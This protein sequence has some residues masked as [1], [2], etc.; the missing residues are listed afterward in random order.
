M[1][2]RGGIANF[3]FNSGFGRLLTEELIPYIDANY[4]TLT[5]QPNRAMAGLSMGGM[6]TRQITLA[7]LD[8]FSHIGI[9]S[10]GSISIDDVNNTPGF[11]DKVKL[12]FVGYG[13]RELGNRVGGGVGGD[14]KE[15]T[16]ALKQAGINTAFYVSPN[17]AH[18]W[19]SWRRDL[20]EF[21]P[22]LFRDNV[23]G[24]INPTNKFALRVN[25][26]SFESYTDKLGNVWAADQESSEDTEWGA[27]YG[28]TVDRTGIGVTGTDH[29]AIY[30][31]ERYSM[32]SYKFTV[33]NGKYTV[34]LHFAETFDGI[35][36]P[37][38]RVF[39]I[40][41]QDQEV[42]KDID[43]FK[44]AGGA[45]KPLVKE[46]KNVSVNNGELVIGFSYNIENPQICGIEVLA[47]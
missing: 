45:I 27:V 15:N 34:R 5:D 32:D 40:S 3:D 2:G 20:H 24:S 8:K 1:G 12:V 43:P 11:K 41:L 47:K 25:C 16:D 6:A 29:P 17:T 9:F 35:Y 33:P 21:A 28:S 22:L 23:S 31:T 44:D 26:G 39:S 13:S 46:F 14:P 38:E 42:L 36:G 19:L 4:R 18:E 10:G 30:E 37:G 7:N